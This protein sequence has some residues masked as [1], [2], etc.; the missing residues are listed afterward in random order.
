[1][2][3]KLEALKKDIAVFKANPKQFR[4]PRSIKRKALELLDNGYTPK[5]LF[6]LTGL[7]DKT[8]HNWKVQNL[9]S[10]KEVRV[11]NTPILSDFEVSVYKA[12]S[13][14]GVACDL[15]K[16]SNHYSERTGIPFKT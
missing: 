13:V 7:G 9:P 16:T 8:L 1:M 5:E 12:H 6:R 2:E 11:S 15:N 4:Y 10:F 3:E 14:K